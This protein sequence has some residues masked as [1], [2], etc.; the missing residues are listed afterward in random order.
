MK[1]FEM[2]NTDLTNFK[3]LSIQSIKGKQDLKK[4]ADELRRIA[5][6][7]VLLDTVL[8]HL[9]SI[10]TL[11]DDRQLQKAMIGTL[12]I[13]YQNTNSSVIPVKQNLQLREATSKPE[14]VLPAL[15]PKMNQ[16]MT[17]RASPK[18]SRRLPR[19]NQSPTARN[20]SPTGRNQSP[21][22]RTSTL[23]R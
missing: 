8:R 1:E 9:K 18:T 15:S 12:F 3:V 13:W 19:L 2:Q 23:D 22:G 21:T 10:Q 20:Q 4:K 11:K 7:Q 16:S 14:L 17:S 5:L 6:K